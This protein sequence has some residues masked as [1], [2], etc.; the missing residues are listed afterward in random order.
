MINYYINLFKNYINSIK[1]EYNWHEFSKI[2]EDDVWVETWTCSNCWLKH[3]VGP[4]D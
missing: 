4:Y 2:N 3:Y 1:C